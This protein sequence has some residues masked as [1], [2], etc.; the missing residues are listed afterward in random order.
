MRRHLTIFP[1]TYTITTTQTSQNTAIMIL[2]SLLS[3]GAF[4]LAAQGFL[5]VPEINSLP[6]IESKAPATLDTSSQNVN[7][8][9]ASCPFALNSLRNGAHEWTG[10]VESDLEMKIVSAD[11]TLNFNN[12]PFFPLH[13][14]SF[15]P[16]LFVS[17]K[18]KDDET[19]TLEG[20]EGNLRLS[21]SMEYNEKKFEDNSL[22]TIVMTIMGLDGQMIKVDNIEIK[23]I[24]EADGKVSNPLTFPE[25]I[26]EA[27][28]KQLTL[29]S[30]NTIPVSPNSPDAKCEDILCR[31]FTKVIT[32][33]NKAKASAK[34]AA[35]KM[36][37]FCVKCFHKLAGHKHHHKGPH[38][39][40]H[41]D[42]MAGVPH[43]RPDGT[44][45]LP[46]H[47]QFK[48]AGHH[49][50]H[51]HH[52]FLG[53]TAM[54][55]RT[56]VQ[57]VLVPILIGVAFGM[58]ASAIGLLVGQAIIFLWMKFRRTPETG[59]YERIDNDEKDAPPMYQDVQAVEAE[60]VS[61]KEV[62]AKA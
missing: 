45:E 34:G 7:I 33:M 24:R 5:V 32:G 46:S 62:E 38:H 23:A 51:H 54:V 39:K 2:S 57:F 55:F 18:K 20:F 37:C 1:A 61:E 14:P 6:E 22:V 8:D 26:I 59:A 28:N 3:A 10:D 47:I 13:N 52:S 42:G 31:I 56:T 40:G 4:S 21:Y 44:M 58:A 41:Q 9:C 50:H 49:S 12:V 29:H 16:I 60:A 43:R 27:K 30:V 17:Q 48:P 35:H 53:K 15:P 11:N 19:S 36:K 25:S